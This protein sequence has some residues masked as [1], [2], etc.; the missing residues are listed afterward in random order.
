LSNEE[1]CPR[2][3]LD[4][5]EELRKLEPTTEEIREFADLHEKIHGVVTY[6]KSRGGEVGVFIRF[7]DTWQMKFGGRIHIDV[8]YVDP[9]CVNQKDVTDTTHLMLSKE[10][11][12]AFIDFIKEKRKRKQENSK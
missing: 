12:V 4:A 1:N 8:G 2:N 7:H 6:S 11:S 9:E 10:Y 5:Y 3:S